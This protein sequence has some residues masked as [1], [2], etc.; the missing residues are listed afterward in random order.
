MEDFRGINTTKMQELYNILLDHKKSISRI[1]SDYNAI[2]N[3]SS[4][5]F[6]GDVANSFKANYN[7]LATQLNQIENNLQDYADAIQVVIGKYISF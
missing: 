1:I 4:T 6:N 5:Y 2:I 7:K 3:N